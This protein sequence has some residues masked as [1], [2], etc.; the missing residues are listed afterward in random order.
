MRTPGT[1]AV[2]P[3][4]SILAEAAEIVDGDRQQHYGPPGENHGRTAALWTAYLGTPVSAADVC[5]LNILQKLSRE[6]HAAK[7]DNLVDVAGYA[8]CMDRIRRGAGGR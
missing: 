5:A 1:D 4:R 6:R 8:E 3:Q 7:R 2:N